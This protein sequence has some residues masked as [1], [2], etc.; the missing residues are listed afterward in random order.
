MVFHPEQGLFA[1]HLEADADIGI[2]FAEL[3]GVADQL[4]H[5][6]GDIFRHAAH[7]Q[8]FIRQHQHETLFL[9]SH[10]IPGDATRHNLGQ[11]EF[12]Y[13]GLGQGL[14]E[15]GGFAHVGEDQPQ[16]VDPFLGA[17]DIL[18]RVLVQLLQTQVLQ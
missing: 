8:R 15:P 11:W 5:Q 6:L 2:G 14:L 7:G 12:I 1:L 13:L 16:A 4:I 9:V 10:L 17:V 18:G 3:N